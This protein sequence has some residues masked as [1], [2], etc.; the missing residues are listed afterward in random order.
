VILAV[1]DIILVSNA[2]SAFVALIISAVILEVF[3]VIAVVFEVILAVFAF[4]L[5]VKV[6]SAALAVAASSVIAVAFAVMLEVFAATAVG[7][8]P[9][10]AAVIPP[11]VFTVVTKLPFP[12]PVTSPVPF[13]DPCIFRML[14]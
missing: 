12:D 5:L 3:A 4:T 1:F 8:P 7:K 2:A 14:L 9:I 6:N 11:T 13:V 10:V